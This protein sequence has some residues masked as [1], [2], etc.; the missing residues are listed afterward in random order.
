MTELRDIVAR[1]PHEPGV[2]RFLDAAGDVLYVGKAKDLRKRVASYF[3]PQGT[4]HGRTGEMLV[5]ARDIEWVVTHSE[6]EALLLE[7]NFI[8]E[9]RPPFNL[10]LRD[11]KSYPYIEVTLTEEWPRV[12]LTRG[13]HVHG[14]L[15]FGPYS[16]A[17]NVRETLTVI[18]RIFPYR[19]CKGA[20][21]GRASGSPCLQ[22]FIHRSL[23]PC[24][25]RVS[26]K[27]YLAVVA[28]VVD[29]LRGRLT[30]VKRGIEK[31]MATAARRQEFE[32]AALLRDRLAAVAHIWERQAARTEGA[33][34]FDVIGL[35]QDEPGANLQ[36][37]LV[38]EG[39][40]VERRTFYVENAGGRE[41]K[42]VLEEFLLEFYWE[43]ATIPAEVIVPCDDLAPVGLVLAARRGA[44]VAVKRAQRGQKRRLLEL[45]QHNAELAAQAE[46]DQASR[47]RDTRIAALER[48]R[49]VLGLSALPLRIEC[50]DISNLGES[51]AV[52]SMVVFE[53]GLP[54]K[55]HYRKF[56]IRDV[57]GQD[58][59]AM[60][61]EVLGRRF[62]RHLA[63]SDGGGA[64]ATTGEKP[65]DDSF[66]ARPDLVVVDGGK[67]QLSAA[68]AALRDAGQDLPVIGLAKQREEVYV[69]S[70]AD[71]IDL[72]ADDPG[73]LLLQRIRD[74]AH[75]FA[76]NFHRQRRD[77]DLRR[78][79][80]FDD[81][82]QVGPVRRRRILEYFGSPERFV[83]ATREELERVPGL[84]VKVAREVYAH[85]HKAG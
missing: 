7:A 81:L 62:E 63:A 16:S 69:P 28:E 48:L 12:R 27:E 71:P 3:R 76:V 57:V 24:D 56:A 1:I 80:I 40:L 60:M 83:A 54:K 64:A 35:C 72:A 73:S 59:F 33:G 44:G 55:A 61:N 5:V 10:M 79:T 13:R 30:E 31:E 47:R 2:Y 29:F 4:P 85:L 20:K 84:P 46:L 19:K 43:A 9:S 32:K 82:P 17:R 36:V 75:R 52:G 78:A 15:Y 66:A 67:G 53:G 22:Y 26:R 65:Y 6:T 18:G 34:S 21:P 70:V 39:A 11:D 14:N 50:Y 68:L 38:R 58:D 77:D 41:A 49:D 8:K 51:H 45:A 42:T 23:A 25:R 74:E 37:F